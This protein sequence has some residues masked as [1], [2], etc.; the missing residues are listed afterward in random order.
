MS[1]IAIFGAG[2]AG[3]ETAWLADH[4]GMKVACLIDD[5]RELEG[6]RINGVPVISLNHFLAISPNVP[7]LCAIGNPQARERVVGKLLKQGAN[8]NCSLIH[9]SVLIGSHTEIGRG[10]IICPHTIITVNVRIGAFAYVNLSCTI[11]HDVELGDFCTFTPGVHVSSTV[12]FGRRIFVGTGATFINGTSTKPL[13][14]GDD[15]VVGAG[16]CVR[17]DVRPGTTL[18]DAAPRSI[19]GGG[20]DREF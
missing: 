15:A 9:P 1:E 16:V 10:A 2:G 7:V 8:L 18:L 19:A 14:V 6:T 3:R 4:C 5:S 17:R 20:A 13:S 11:G 12:R